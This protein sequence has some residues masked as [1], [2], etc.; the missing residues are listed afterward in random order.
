MD[1]EK[2]LR[3]MRE[4]MFGGGLLERLLED[5]RRELEATDTAV[6]EREYREGTAAL[7]EL[8][9]GGQ[10][11][12][13][14]EL[15]ALYRENLLYGLRFSFFQGLRAALWR[16][17]GGTAFGTLVEE[18]LLRMPRMAEQP[19]YSQR[20]RRIQEIEERLCGSLSEADGQHVTS[21]TLGWD[22]RLY[23]VLRRGFYLGSRFALAAVGNPRMEK[24]AEA[25]EESLAF[26]TG[27]FDEEE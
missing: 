8:L 25:I 17:G 12:A 20:D 1:M 21:V 24:T 4:R 16:H 7:A 14:A 23:G 22:E 5:G 13:L 18:P 2:E 6:S 19:G 26:P 27:W 11:A 10:R 3:M 9:D 15:E